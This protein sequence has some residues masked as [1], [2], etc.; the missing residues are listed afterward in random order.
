MRKSSV[1]FR[2][3]RNIRMILKVRKRA[4]LFDHRSTSLRLFSL[5]YGYVKLGIVYF[6]DVVYM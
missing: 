5:V 2:T 4:T 6:A 3:D 1:I